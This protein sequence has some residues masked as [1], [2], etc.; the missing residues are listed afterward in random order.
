MGEKWNNQVAPSTVPTALRQ[1]TS[2][3]VN[4]TTGGL[5]TEV[6]R[7]TVFGSYIGQA[8]QND[9]GGIARAPKYPSV[10]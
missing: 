4:L 3:T 1:S 8:N 2:A 9:P 10:E 7:S 5:N 6:Y